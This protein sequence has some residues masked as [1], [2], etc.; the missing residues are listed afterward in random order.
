MKNS[1]NDILGKKTKTKVLPYKVIPEIRSTLVIHVNKEST[2]TL[3]ESGWDDRY[4]AIVENGRTTRVEYE[5]LFTDEIKEKYRFDPVKAFNY[6]NEKI[7]P[8]ED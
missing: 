3:T 8:N 2:L 7:K 6:Y 4:H 5:L 1:N